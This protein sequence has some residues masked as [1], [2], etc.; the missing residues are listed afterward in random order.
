MSNKVPT[1]QYV[2]VYHKGVNQSVLYISRGSSRFV[3]RARCRLRL[4]IPE[5]NT[6]MAKWTCCW[7]CPDWRQRAL[8][9]WRR[10]WQLSR[11]RV[12]VMNGHLVMGHV[13]G[14]NCSFKSLGSSRCYGQFDSP[15]NQVADVSC[16]I[17]QLCLA[18]SYTQIK[19]E[20]LEWLHVANE[21]VNSPG[22]TFVQSVQIFISHANIYM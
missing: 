21:S 4:C 10:H 18:H 14:W 22:E 12:N 1:V 16:W 8:W 9:H 15:I 3:N 17:S 7:V 2:H 6:V 13:L 11:G 20:L 19:E 5:V